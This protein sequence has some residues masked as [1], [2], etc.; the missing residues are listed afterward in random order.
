MSHQ[1]PLRMLQLFSELFQYEPIHPIADELFYN[2]NFI[3]MLA[4]ICRQHKLS[5]PADSHRGDIYV[6]QASRFMQQH[7]DKDIQIESVAQYI[8]LERSYF[9]K[10]FKARTGIAPYEYIMNL[11]CSKGKLLLLET[12]MPVEHIA[13]MIGFKDSFHFSSFFKKKTGLSPLNY[14]IKRGISPEE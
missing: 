8:G 1:R 3:S 14:R 5:A 7:Y 2:G 10:V 11:R 9:S 4:E 12:A 13:L 6:Q